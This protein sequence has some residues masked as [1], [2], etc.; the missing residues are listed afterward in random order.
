MVMG[1]KLTKETKEKLSKS[2]KEGLANGSI[3]HNWSGRKTNPESH[4]EQKFREALIKCGVSAHQFYVPP[5]ND[6]FYE[7]D[8]AIIDKKINWE[9][10]GLFHYKSGGTYDTLASRY[11]ERH[12]YLVNKGWRVIEINYSESLVEGSY[13]SIIRKT[14]ENENYDYSQSPE[15]IS[16]RLKRNEKIVDKINNF[17]FRCDALLKKSNIENKFDV[18]SRSDNYRF[19]FYKEQSIKS[20]KLNQKNKNRIER[21]LK[22]YAEGYVKHIYYGRKIQPNY[23][24]EREKDFIH[25]NDI[26][27]INSNLDNKIEILSM[28]PNS[29]MYYYQEIK[30]TLSAIKQKGKLCFSARKVDRPSKEELEKLIWEKPTTQLAKDFDVSDKAIEK[31]CKRYGIEKPRRGYWA[32]LAAGKI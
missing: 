25:R 31:W 5:E 15:V 10:N 20:R 13:E 27:I 11:Q 17:L 29:R 14:L 8:F 32:K 21:K 23:D 12:D 28:H 7:L 26:C 18:L 22:T 6:R 2:R 16:F 9:I 19:Y 3:P 24:F 30:Y 1:R 4:A